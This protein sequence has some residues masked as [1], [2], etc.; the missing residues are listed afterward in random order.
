M[1]R[2]FDDSTAP[3]NSLPAT[4]SPCDRID[5]ASGAVYLRRI[6]A[7]PPGARPVLFRSLAPLAGLALLAVAGYARWTPPARAGDMRP[8]PHA[9]QNQ[10]RAPSQGRGA[11]DL[12]VVE[13]R[14]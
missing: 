9:R 12:G 1:R 13:G 11:G 3:I 8:R 7:R 14:R 4:T 6:P 10:A 5:G 2:A